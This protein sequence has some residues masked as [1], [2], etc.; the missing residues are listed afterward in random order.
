M[1]K[2]TQYQTIT[3]DSHRELTTKLDDRAGKGWR[4][5][6][7]TVRQVGYDVDLEL[8]PPVHFPAKYRRPKSRSNRQKQPTY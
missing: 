2:T 4:A 3:A 8:R 1:A 6:R 5:I 7:V